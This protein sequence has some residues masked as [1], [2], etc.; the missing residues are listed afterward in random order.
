MKAVVAARAGSGQIA[1]LDVP[2]PRC[3]RTEVIVGVEAAGICGSDIHILQGNISWDMAYPVTLG[4][5]FCGVIVEV[6]DD[7]TSFS[8]GDR[9]VSETAA[10]IDTNGEWYRTGAYNLDPD[11][12][13]FGVR[14]DGGMAERVA[15][16][17][18]CLH[19]LPEAVSFRQGALTEPTCV[20]Y[21]ATCVQTTVCP[22]D[23]VAVV[24]AGTIGLL[25][26]WLAARSGASLVIVVGLPRD[27]SRFSTIES[28][29]A[30]EMATSADSARTL[31]ERRG[32]GGADVVI[33][34]AGAS[35]ALATALD[36]VR[37]NGQVTMVGMGLGPFGRSLDPVV[38]KQLTI[39]GSFSHTWAVWKR[40]LG[41]LSDGGG[42]VVEQIV[43]WEGAIEEWADGF[44]RQAD[45]H[46]VKAMLRPQAGRPNA[47]MR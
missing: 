37:P 28:L 19:Q 17:E 38:A 44:K 26:A 27:E 14:V 18:R 43:G 9:V 30:I 25:C 11:R 33:D 12:R 42:E 21:Q 15:V 31:L 36:L 4:H 45:G 20:A 6:G 7:V 10:G 8:V 13:G 32:R 34:A 16:P 22:G 1:L 2:E 23:A 3:G 39:R 35:A 5:E 24:G 29:G 46:V 40:V 41:L 47:E